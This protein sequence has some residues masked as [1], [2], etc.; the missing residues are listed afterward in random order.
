MRGGVNLMNH[1]CSQWHFGLR[2]SEALKVLLH[3]ASS[4]NSRCSQ[5]AFELLSYHGNESMAKRTASHWLQRLFSEFRDV[6]ENC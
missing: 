3:V 5:R 4:M 1:S 6:Q 2:I